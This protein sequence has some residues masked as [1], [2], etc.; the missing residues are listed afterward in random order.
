MSLTVERTAIPTFV[1]SLKALQGILSKGAAYA[2]AKDIDASVLVNSRLSADMHPLK[3]QVQMVS[4]TVRR[5]LCQLGGQDVPS[6]EDSEETF[7]EL[8][9]RVQATLDF[10]AAFDKSSLAGSEDRTITLPIGDAGLDLDGTTFLM[11][12]GIPNFYFHMAAAYNIL[13]H[14]GVDVGKMDFLGAP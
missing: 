9:T 5:V 6:V 3:R 11:S 4:D 12:F 8:Q 14:N 7:A 10:I 2:E 1:R 13:R